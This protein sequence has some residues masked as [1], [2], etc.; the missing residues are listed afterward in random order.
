MNSSESMNIVI[1][2]DSAFK[3]A[4]I[5]SVSVHAGLFLLLLLSPYLPKPSKK[6]MIHYVNMV[7]LPGGGPG[8][9]GGGQAAVITEEQPGETAVPQRQS[10][11]DLTLP[12]KLEQVEPTLRHPTDNPERENKPRPK[13]QAVIQKQDPSVK[14]KA[15]T[16]ESSSEQSGTGSGPGLRIGGVGTGGGGGFGSE[17]AGQIGLSNFLFNYYVQSIG[18]KIS[19]N[20]ITAQISSGVKGSYGT[21]VAFKIYRSG[22]ISTVDV[23]ESSKI[24]T[25]DMSARRAV[26]NSA[27][28]PPLPAEYEYDYLEIILIFEHSR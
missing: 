4:V 17:Y 10:L 25:L 8:G 13:K 19:S 7:S 2:R 20:W 28:F 22:R 16:R 6:G 9:G 11:K 21:T 24:Q 26:M 3:R 1:N 5:I 27:P 14:K 23:R 12:E 15:T 18:A